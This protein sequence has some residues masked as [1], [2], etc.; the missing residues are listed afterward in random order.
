MK[1]ITTLSDSQFLQLVE[2]QGF[3]SAAVFF[4][5]LFTEEAFAEFTFSNWKSLCDLRK[6]NRSLVRKK[7]V[8]TAQTF[9]EWNSVLNEVRTDWHDGKLVKIAVQEMA[10]LAKDFDEFKLILPEVE[11]GLVKDNFCKAIKVAKA[12]NDWKFVF[13]ES[14]RYTDGTLYDYYQIAFKEMVKTASLF[15]D[16]DEIRSEIVG[17]SSLDPDGSLYMLAV[18][19]MCDAAKTLYECKEAH[20]DAYFLKGKN[21]VEGI[22]CEKIVLNKMSELDE[23]FPTWLGVY[24]NCHWSA[25]YEDYHEVSQLGFRKM[26]DTAQTFSQRTEVWSYVSTEDDAYKLVVEKLA[27]V[28]KTYEEWEIVCRRSWCVPSIHKLSLKEIAKLINGFKSWQD[29]YLYTDVEDIKKLAFQ[30]MQELAYTE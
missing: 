15:S 10:K 6:F 2:K 22:K 4:F 19:K 13:S 9:F 16:W 24:D 14:G 26:L 1:K 27:E 7:M 8:E 29:I 30:K 25:D 17:H 28:A 12:F 3:V 11:R 18:N 5:E 20:H 21:K 23:D